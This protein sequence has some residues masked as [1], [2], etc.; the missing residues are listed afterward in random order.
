MASRISRE[1]N[2]LEARRAGPLRRPRRRRGA[3]LEEELDLE[4]D[5]AGRPGNCRGR[6]QD[7]PGE[8]PLHWMLPCRGT[9][10]AIFPVRA[11]TNQQEGPP[12]GGPSSEPGESPDYLTSV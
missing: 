1:V 6:C 5:E 9:E 10:S 2:R 12:R 7:E 8:E 11:H 4:G 3:L